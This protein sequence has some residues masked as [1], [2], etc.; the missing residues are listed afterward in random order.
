MAHLNLS[1]SL[2]RQPPW[3]LLQR[4]GRRVARL[5]LCATSECRHTVT[6]KTHIYCRAHK[7]LRR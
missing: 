4:R 1:Q 2:V 6:Q 3:V 7:E 5:P